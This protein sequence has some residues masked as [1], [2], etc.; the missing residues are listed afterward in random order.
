MKMRLW[1]SRMGKD[2]DQEVAEFSTSINEDQELYWFDIIGS[3]A[4]CKMLQKIEILNQ[5]EAQHIQRGLVQLLQNIE[6]NQ[7]NLNVYEDIHS[8]VE[9]NLKQMIGEPAEKLHRREVVTIK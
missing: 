3:L 2:L 6:K 4:H 5:T 8:A 1:G 7:I 9:I